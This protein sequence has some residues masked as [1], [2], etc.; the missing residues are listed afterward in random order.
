MRCSIDLDS[1]PRTSTVCYK[2]ASAFRSPPVEDD[3]LL[4]STLTHEQIA[5]V[6]GASRPRVSLALKRLEREGVFVREGKQI[7]VHE[8][9]LRRYLEGKYEYLL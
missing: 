8:R 5:A 4:P 9:S 3:C 6:L 7:R 2:G 1:Q